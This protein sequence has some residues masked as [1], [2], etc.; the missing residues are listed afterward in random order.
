SSEMLFHA[1]CEQRQRINEDWP[2][3]P[4]WDYPKSKIKTEELIKANHG[5]MPIVLLRIAGVYDDLCHSIP[6]AHQIQRIYERSLT[7]HLFP[8][9]MSHGQSFVHLNDLVDVCWLL[10][11]R[12]SQL[13]P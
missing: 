1:D 11:E 2:L 3:E 10:T 7:S 6:L 8:G 13:P 5:D 9:D 4:K 12:R